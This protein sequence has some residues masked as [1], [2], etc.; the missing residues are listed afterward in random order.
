MAVRAQRRGRSAP[1]QVDEE[2]HRKLI[3][4]ARQEQKEAKK[5]H[6]AKTRALGQTIQ[7]AMDAGVEVTSIAKLLK[8]SR[9]A[10][11]KLASTPRK[12]NPF[13]DKR[14]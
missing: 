14:K 6:E 5:I 4:S 12:K 9:Q 13:I 7:K 10:V 2:R 11:Y 1:A 8:I 3:Q